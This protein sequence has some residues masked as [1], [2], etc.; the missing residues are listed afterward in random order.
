MANKTDISSKR[1]KTQVNI[2]RYN[3]QSNHQ[4][5]NYIFITMSLHFFVWHA[6]IFVTC[7]RANIVA[8][9]SATIQQ[10]RR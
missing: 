2:T 7:V 1:V 8:K 3:K 6:N 5:L 4:D 9:T 10:G